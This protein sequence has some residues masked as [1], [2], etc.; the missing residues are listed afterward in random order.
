ML[1]K[2]AM[3][4]S[5]LNWLAGGTP[6][7]GERGREALQ[8]ALA[9]L[10]VELAGSDDHFDDAER[11]V[12]RRLLERRFNLSPEEGRALLAVGE[13]EAGRSAE[14]FHFARVINER[15]SPEQRIELIEML[16]EV[17][18]ADGVLDQYE[19]TLLRRIAGLIYVADR[20][21]GLARRRVARRLGLDTAE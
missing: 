11:A 15:L 4:D 16:W 8:V 18:L 21:R 12:I 14:L 13:R 5:I 9:A 17:A 1:G 3:I 6:A 20:E 19:D 10:F 2:N 7:A